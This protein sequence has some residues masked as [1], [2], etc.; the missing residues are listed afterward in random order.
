V[1]TKDPSTNL[2]GAVIKDNWIHGNH[3]VGLW[4]DTND[5]GFSITGNYF[6]GGVAAPA[7]A[8]IMQQALGAERVPPAP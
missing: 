1:R 8:Q 7:F 4:V 3:G 5:S 2:N 6:G